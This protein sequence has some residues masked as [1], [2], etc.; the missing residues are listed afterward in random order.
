MPPLSVA[1]HGTFEHWPVVGWDT[2]GGTRGSLV[3][4]ARS[5][6]PQSIPQTEVLI[7]VYRT[8]SVCALKK[9]VHLD[10]FVAGSYQVWGALK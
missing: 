10:Y 6:A 3:I 4:S 2:L 5:A 1:A 7:V 8:V 9:R